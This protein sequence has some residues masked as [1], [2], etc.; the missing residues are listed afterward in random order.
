M[1]DNAWIQWGCLSVNALLGSRVKPAPAVSTQLNMFAIMQPLFMAVSHYRQSVPR[2]TSVFEFFP[3]LHIVGIK[4][5]CK[6]C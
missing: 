2:V 4:G 6:E 1:V 3:R 5:L